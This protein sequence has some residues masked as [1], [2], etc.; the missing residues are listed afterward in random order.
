[1]SNAGL[2]THRRPSSQSTTVCFLIDIP[3][4]S[5]LCTRLPCL[6]GSTSAVVSFSAR[7]CPFPTGSRTPRWH[8]QF[9]PVLTYFRIS[10]FRMSGFP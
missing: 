4:H 8:R 6:S 9:S 3:W 10:P 2:N 1:M 5:R 7:S